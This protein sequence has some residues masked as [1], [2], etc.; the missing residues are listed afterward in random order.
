MPK[1][2]PTLTEALSQF[3]LDL[4]EDL[5][6]LRRGDITLADARVRAQLAREVLRSVGL[7]LEGMRY[8]AGQALPAPQ[9]KES[10]DGIRK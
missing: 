3:T 4:V 7:Q 6:S 9:Q 8:L 5:R 2:P 10:T 1:T